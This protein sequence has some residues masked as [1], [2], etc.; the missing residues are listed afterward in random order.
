MKAFGILLKRELM[1]Y[2]CSPIAYLVTMFFL[3][4]IGFSFWMLIGILAQGTLSVTILSELFGSIFF[5]IAMLIVVPILTMRLF[6]EE[7][8]SGTIETLMTAPVTDTEVVLSK[9]AGA[10][11]F[12][13]LMWLPTALYLL[14]LHR[15]SPIEAPPDWG[16][17][18][19]GYAGAFLVGA[20][21]LAVGTLCSALTRN[22]I[23]AA[24]MCFACISILFF[25][26]FL[27]YTARDPWVREWSSYISS[28]EYMRDFARGA[29]DSRALV[30]HLSG[31]VFV[32]FATVKIME[33]R[34]WI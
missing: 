3:A 1:A 30:F 18:V 28:V 10:L 4:M 23:V 15:L 26:G 2:F 19:S 9:Y 13:V 27:T 7:K 33:S 12:F 6:A 22:Q 21:Y 5:W 25:T 34:R 29:W 32:L 11:L 8:R 24:I 16:A 17:F 31:T 14:I 20:L